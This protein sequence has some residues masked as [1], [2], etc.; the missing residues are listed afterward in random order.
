VPAFNVRSKA[1]GEVVAVVY[2][3]S[4]SQAVRRVL[5]TFGDVRLEHVEAFE[6]V[7]VDGD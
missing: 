1:T 3:R 7:P 4:A 2:A 6:A 5:V